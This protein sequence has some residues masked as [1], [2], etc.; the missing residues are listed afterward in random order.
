MEGL[1]L[2]SLNI[3]FLINLKSNLSVRDLHLNRRIYSLGQ[4]AFLT[5][6]SDNV[7]FANANVDT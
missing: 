1:L 2:L 7:I 6:Y 4:F 5:L 3:R